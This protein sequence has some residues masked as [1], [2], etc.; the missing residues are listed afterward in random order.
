M[1]KRRGPD[2]LEAA[3]A[4]VIGVLGHQGA[5]DAVERGTTTIYAWS[6]PD[7]REQPGIRH[8]LRLDRACRAA[9]EGTPIADWY[10]AQLGEPPDAGGVD[11]AFRGVTVELG[12]LARQYDRAAADGRI[13]RQEA[14]ALHGELADLRAALDRLDGAL[15]GATG[16]RVVGS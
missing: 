8:A 7:G 12:E 5:A 13:D 4:R 2:T 11:R 9:G 3:I 10:L 6:D 14:D 1:T 15:R 16:L